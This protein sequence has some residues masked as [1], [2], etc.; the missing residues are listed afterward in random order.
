MAALPASSKCLHAAEYAKNLNS[1]IESFAECGKSQFVAFRIDAHLF[2]AG[3][4][5]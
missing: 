3:R 2:N 4:S 5:P 1:F